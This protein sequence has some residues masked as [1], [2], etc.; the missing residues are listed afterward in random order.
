MASMKYRGRRIFFGDESQDAFQV[1][2][3]IFRIQQSLHACLGAS[4]SATLLVAVT[5]YGQAEDRQ[6]ALAAGFDEHLVKPLDLRRVLEVL[7]N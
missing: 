6:R 1:I 4:P 2:R 7:S 3:G 5:G